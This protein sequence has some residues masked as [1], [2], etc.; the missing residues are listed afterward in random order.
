MLKLAKMLSLGV[1]SFDT[2]KSLFSRNPPIW[3]DPKNEDLE[4]RFISA[5][6]IG[7]DYL[8]YRSPLK[9]CS[10]LL[11]EPWLD[12]VNTTRPPS[13]GGVHDAGQVCLSN[14]TFCLLVGL[15]Y[16]EP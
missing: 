4:I 6:M 8:E 10:P 9:Y 16:I 12:V 15:D 1:T 2:S 3:M 5:S 7:R 13:R 14:T 11:R